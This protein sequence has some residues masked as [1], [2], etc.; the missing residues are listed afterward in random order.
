MI[1]L[2][3]TFTG[4]CWLWETEKASWHFITLPKDKSE[5]IKFFNESMGHKKRGWGSV[6]VE[7]TIGNTTW[8]TSIFPQAKEGTYILPLKA[9]VRRKE[10]VLLGND[11]CVALLI[12]V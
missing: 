7:A 1:D 2:S 3:F 10:K 12:D 6:R 9:E 5:E 4:K 11:V 8:Q